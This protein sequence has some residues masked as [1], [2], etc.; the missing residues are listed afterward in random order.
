METTIDQTDLRVFLASRIPEARPELMTL[1]G[2][3]S[4][5]ATL[6]KLYE[7]TSILAHQ[8][9]FKAVRR[10]LQTAEELLLEEDKRI[11][12]AVCS[13]YIYRL[14]MLLDKRDA[15]AEVIHYLLPRGIRTEY[16]RQLTACQS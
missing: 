2:G 9:R 6:N 7:I 11:S 16:Q 3:V 10:C 12:N 4:L 15:R 14:S 13:I 8:N 5:H 1:P